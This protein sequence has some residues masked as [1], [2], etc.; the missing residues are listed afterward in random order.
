M[1]NLKGFAHIFSCLEFLFK[2]QNFCSHFALPKKIQKIKKK[3]LEKFFFSCL[4]HLGG[5][6]TLERRNVERP[7]FRNFEIAKIKIKKGQLFDNSVFE[8]CF[9]FLEIV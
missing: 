5:G 1:L 3:A 4:G 9:D 6:Q 2:S 7:V 8:L